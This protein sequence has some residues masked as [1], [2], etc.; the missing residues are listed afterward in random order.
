MK[1]I[2]FPIIAVSTILAGISAAQ[3]GWQLTTSSPGHV[4]RNVQHVVSIP[5]N[6][7]GDIYFFDRYHVTGSSDSTPPWTLFF[8]PVGPPIFTRHE[9]YINNFG[10]APTSFTALYDYTDVKAK[11]G[12]TK[13]GIERL[14]ELF[15]L[16]YHGLPE[17][18]G[19]GA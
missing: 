10:G 2:K 4:T 6:Y 16:Y 9:V 19:A 14:R 13:D 17:R 7:L 3:S 8:L 5:A 12:W 1:R 15:S 11:Q 18:P